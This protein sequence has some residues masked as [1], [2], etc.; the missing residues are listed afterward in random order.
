MWSLVHVIFYSAP[1][2]SLSSPECVDI[3]SFGEGQLVL[4]LARHHLTHN[5]GSQVAQPVMGQFQLVFTPA[6]PG[7]GLLGRQHTACRAPHIPEPAERRPD[8]AHGP[9]PGTGDAT[10]KSQPGFTGKWSEHGDWQG[11]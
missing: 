7:V 8:P 11:P 10:G 2:A 6:G 1:P 3:S 9:S 4:V 5:L